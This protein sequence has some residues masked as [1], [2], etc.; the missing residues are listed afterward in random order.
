MLQCFNSASVATA[1]SVGCFVR[2]VYA[3][4]TGVKKRT[5]RTA[6]P[7]SSVLEGVGCY[8]CVGGQCWLLQFK[9]YFVR[10]WLFRLCCW[11]PVLVVTLYSSASAVSGVGC[12]GC[13]ADQCW[14]LRC[15]SPASAVVAAVAGAGCFVH[16]RGCWLFTAP[17]LWSPLPV[18]VVSAV[19]LVSV[20]CSLRSYSS[21]YVVAAA[22]AGCFGCVAG[23]LCWL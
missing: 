23:H 16:G 12:F 11:S 3:T 21:A 20:G 18:L 2:F 14:L 22:D 8:T 1:A 10:C 19:L 9:L 5:K 15:Y 17:P 4:A 7:L 13:V 6:P